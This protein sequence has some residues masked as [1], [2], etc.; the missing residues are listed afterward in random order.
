VD[1]QPLFF[2][3]VYD[4]FKHIVRVVGP[5]EAGVALFP[6]K[7]HDP[8]SAARFLADNLNPDRGE[9]LDL[10]QLVQLLRLGKE[11]GCHA[12]MD[13]ICH[14]AGYSRPEPVTAQDEAAEMIRNWNRIGTEIRQLAAKWPAKFPGSDA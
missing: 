14:A 2:E 13:Y 12:A 5:K 6:K 11:K 3:D 8:Q 4:A 7:A 10:E 9:K 1:Q